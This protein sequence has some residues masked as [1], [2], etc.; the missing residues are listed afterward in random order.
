MDPFA[1]SAGQPGTG[2]GRSRHGI[3]AS[4]W[5]HRDRIG[6][7]AGTRADPRRHPESHAGRQ[8]RHAGADTHP[9]RKGGNAWRINYKCFWWTTTRWFAVDFAACW[10]TSPPFTLWARPA[11]AW[12]RLS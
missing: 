3:R 7:D 1:L 4:V 2:S 8:W 9:A 11:M 5:A 12:K 6:G 10:R